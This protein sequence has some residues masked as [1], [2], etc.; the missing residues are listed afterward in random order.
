MFAYL[1]FLAA[2]TPGIAVVNTAPPPVV[3]PPQSLPPEAIQPPHALHAGDGQQWRSGRGHDCPGNR[4]E[5]RRRPARGATG[6]AAGS[7]TRQRGLKLA[8][9]AEL[10]GLGL[11]LV[12]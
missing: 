5:V 8:R 9:W 11:P 2:V 12:G 10:P 3:L 4:M 1:L 7:V 6:P